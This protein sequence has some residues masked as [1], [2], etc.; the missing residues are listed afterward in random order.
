[1]S[2]AAEIYRAA[3][4]AELNTALHTPP[5]GLDESSARALVERALQRAHRAG[6]D[7]LVRE[8]VE[9]GAEAAEIA[10]ERE[11]E[12]R[13][14]AAQAEQRQREAALR[15]QYG[16]ELGARIELDGIYPLVRHQAPK[17]A[18]EPLEDGSPGWASWPGRWGDTRPRF[19]GID[20]PSPTGPVAHEQWDDPKRLLEESRSPARR[21]PARPPEVEVAR[22]AG[23][24]RLHYDF[25]R[26][27]GPEPDKLVVT[28]NSVDDHLPPRTFTFT[29]EGAVRGT[30]D[31]R[32]ALSDGQ[33]YDIYISTTDVD[34][35]PS[36]SKL[37][38]LEPVGERQPAS[39]PILPAIGRFVA[40]VRGVL[41]RRR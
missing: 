9:W 26:R 4:D 34:G 31:T 8:L 3:H 16:P 22:R 25:S 13:A 23:R 40:F 30:I 28:V 29:V 12:E 1:V 38:M 19:G 24:L 21:D 41:A 7:A 14:E 20:Q 18:L 11:K 5:P 27:P 15:D 6:R 36:E 33:H 17:L 32:L 39:I 37:T 35:R 2:T 10:R